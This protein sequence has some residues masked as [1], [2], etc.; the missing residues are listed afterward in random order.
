[1]CSADN[2]L[3]SYVRSMQGA[4]SNRN[5]AIIMLVALL[6]G[7]FLGW[8]VAAESEQTGLPPL[9]PVEHHIGCVKALEATVGIGHRETVRAVDVGVICAVGI[10]I[11]LSRQHLEVGNIA[12]GTYVAKRGNNQSHDNTRHALGQAEE[13]ASM[14]AA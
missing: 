5:I 1:M 12:K 14:F 11:G 9:R 10:S 6:L 3:S 13:E 8:I 7:V 4:E 2:T